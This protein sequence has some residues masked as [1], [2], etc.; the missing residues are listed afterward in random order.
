[1]GYPAG[2]ITDVVGDNDAK[3]CA[4]NAVCPQQAMLAL[5]LLC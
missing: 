5:A 2:W 4:G 1:M 3:R